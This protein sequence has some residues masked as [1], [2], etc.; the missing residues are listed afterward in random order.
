MLEALHKVLDKSIAIYGMNYGTVGF[1]MNAADE[2][3]L[4]QRLEN[5]QPSVLHPLH[6]TATTVAGKSKV[7]WHSMTSF[8]SVRR[9]RRPVSG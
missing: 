4:L 1:L 2:G 5:A 8:F 3:D 6:M 9:G 7:H